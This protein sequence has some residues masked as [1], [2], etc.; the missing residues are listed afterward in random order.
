MGWVT[1]EGGV[2]GIPGAIEAR[3]EEGDVLP[4]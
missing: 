2:F 4:P 1:R 3:T